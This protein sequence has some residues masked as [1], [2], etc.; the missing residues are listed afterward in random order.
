M[1]Y[2]PSNSIPPAKKRIFYGMIV[3]DWQFFT[4]IATPISHWY[5]CHIVTALQ[6]NN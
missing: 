2:G 5:G 1:D 4:N 3:T 6:A